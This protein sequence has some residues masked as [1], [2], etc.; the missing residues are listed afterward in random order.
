MFLSLVT[1]IHPLPAT[2]LIHSSSGAKPRNGG[3]VPPAL[4]SR[5]YM[6]DLGLAVGE[7]LVSMRRAATLLESSVDDLSDLFAVH[8]V[9]QP[10]EP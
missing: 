3:N 8:G 10:A 7:G 2:D 5:P 6:E 4:F 9:A 1:A